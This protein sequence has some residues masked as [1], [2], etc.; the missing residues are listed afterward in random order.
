MTRYVLTSA[1]RA[2]VEAIWDY[3]AA[4][5]GVDQAETYL[6]AIQTTFQDL[7]AGQRIAQSIDTIREGY[8]RCAVGSHVVF[9][10]RAPAGD[11]QVIRILHNRMDVPRHL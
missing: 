11:I 5:W 9:F 7:A 10:R 4:R 6:R 3:T 8:F 1:A 2:D